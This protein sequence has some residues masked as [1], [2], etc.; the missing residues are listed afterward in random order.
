MADVAR[1]VVPVAYAWVA[2][3]VGSCAASIFLGLYRYLPA[4]ATS[5]R[6]DVGV[7]EVW[8]YGDMGARTDG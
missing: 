8:E 6:T 4:Y 2:A 1:T 5:L 3:P 7:I